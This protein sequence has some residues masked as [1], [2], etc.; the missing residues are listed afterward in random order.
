MLILKMFFRLSQMYQIFVT[1]AEMPTH[2]ETDFGVSSAFGAGNTKIG[3]L[4]ARRG[5]A[6][7]KPIFFL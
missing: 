4:I 5:R 1:I 2:Y 7:T 3:F 6:V